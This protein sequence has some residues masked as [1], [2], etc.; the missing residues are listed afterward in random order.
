MNG[1]D[2]KPPVVILSGI[3]WDFLWQRHQILATLF[4]RAGYPTVF[5]ETTGLRNLS[6]DPSTLRKVLRRLL[7]AARK[8]KVPDDEGSKAS[9]SGDRGGTPSNLVV[10]SP[11]VAPPTWKVFRRLN[12]RL[13]VP[14]VVRDLQRHFLK[15]VSPVVVAYPPTRTT[16]DILSELKPRLTVYDCSENYE[17]FPGIPRDVKLTERELLDRADLVSCTSAFLLERVGPTRPDAFLSG[18]GV[19]YDR[20]AVLQGAQSAGAHSVG[21]VRTVCFFGHMSEERVDFSILTGLAE[22]GFEVRLVGGLGRVGEGL[23]LIPGVDYRGEVSHA[24]LPAALSGTDAFII[25]YRINALTLGISPA[26]IYECLATGIPVVATPLPE[27]KRMERHIY[28]AEGA[29]GF[30]EVLRDLPRLESGEA[31]RA[32]VKLARENSWEARF[33]DIEKEIRRKL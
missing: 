18:P 7:Q 8:R 24:D 11:L 9:G 27:L 29:E 4:A 10:Y 16:L 12:R 26:K 21:P 31:V 3:R 2:R 28:L 6:P 14:R 23:F 15:G 1:P 30:A 32:R 13:L 33:T 20:F 5:V 17:G 19:D 25:P 22:R